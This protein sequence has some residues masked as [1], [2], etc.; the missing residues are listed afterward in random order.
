MDVILIKCKQKV[1]LS[2]DA[3][4]STEFC[5]HVYF[6]CLGYLKGTCVTFILRILNF[7]HEK[8]PL[9]ETLAVQRQCYHA[10]MTRQ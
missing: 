10:L 2:L 9:S 8:S 5:F 1:C 3:K 6:Y 4:A 7:K